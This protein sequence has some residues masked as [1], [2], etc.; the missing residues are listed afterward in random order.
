MLEV[1]DL[2]VPYGAVKALRSVSFTAA[3]GAIT[4]IL[5]ANGAGKTTLLRAISGWSSPRAGSV[6]LRRRRAPRARGRRTSRGAAWPTSRR[7]GHHRG[8]DGGG[9]P[10]PGHA[11]VPAVAGSGRPP[12]TRSSSSFPGWPTS[13]V[14]TPRPCRV[15]S[16]RCWSSVERLISRPRLLLL[17]EP[18]L[19]LA[20]LIT[21]Q[22]MALLRDQTEGSDMTVVLV[23]QNARS[24][25]SVSRSSGGAQPRRGGGGRLGGGR[26]RPT[27]ACATTTWGSREH[28]M[29]L[30][31]NYT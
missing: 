22:L 20:P 13:G 7:A 24:A 9:E 18:S 26:W 27:R 16:A 3:P 25:L 8:T 17:D 23:E 19:G 10:P 4:A 6:T 5:G 28:R 21:A 29:S 1:K 15:A 31:F 11:V 14:A 12:S 2:S 30:F